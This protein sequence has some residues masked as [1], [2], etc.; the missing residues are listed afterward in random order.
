MKTA[1]LFVA[2]FVGC[3][4]AIADEKQQN[5]AE[6]VTDI[7]SRE[8]AICAAYYQI[9]STGLERAG[10]MNGA[11]SAN[12]LSERAFQYSYS[13]AQ[14]G[15]TTEEARKVV[16]SRLEFYVKDMMVD[17]ENDMSNVSILTNKYSHQCKYAI[18]EPDALFND[19]VTEV[20]KGHYK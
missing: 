9:V 20:L 12:S 15:R 4:V 7:V 10:M 11:A 14:R 17:I 1:S 13:A 18:E 6:K 3:C 5:L 19:V 16:L 8:Y 2:L